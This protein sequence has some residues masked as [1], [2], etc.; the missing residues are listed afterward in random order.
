MTTTTTPSPV[1]TS[2]S[3][4]LKLMLVV[5]VVTLLLRKPTEILFIYHTIIVIT[6]II[7]IIII[8]LSLST[9]KSQSI[10][11]T[12]YLSPSLSLAI[13]EP[14][15]SKLLLM[16]PPSFNRWPTNNV[17]QSTQS[18]GARDMSHNKLH[19]NAS[20]ITNEGWVLRDLGPGTA[21]PGQ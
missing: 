1:K 11:C 3:E 13:T 4:L 21:T 20:C 18:G 7:I 17:K 16:W 14:R 12:I 19:I 8:K 6:I 10:F 15:A 9:F 5:N 2:L